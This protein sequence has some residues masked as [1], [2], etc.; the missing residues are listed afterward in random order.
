MCGQDHP[1]AE[2]NSRPHRQLFQKE[3]EPPDWR[4]IALP[5]PAVLKLLTDSHCHP[6][7]LPFSTAQVKNVGLGGLAAMATR[8]HDQQLVESFGETYG[9]GKDKVDDEDE[10]TQVVACFGYHP[11]FSHLLSLDT[12]KDP[13][14]KQ[15]HY[16]SIFIPS[17]LSP[18]KKDEYH[19]ILSRIIHLF[20]E[21]VRLGPLLVDMGQR[22]RR[23]LG[24]GQ[25]VMVGEIGLDRSFRIPY[26]PN[27]TDS[28]GTAHTTTTTVED[29][30]NAIAATAPEKELA[31]KQD[32][33][34]AAAKTKTKTKTLTPFTTSTAHQLRVL[35]LQFQVALDCGVNVSLHSVKAQGKLLVLPLF[36]H[37]THIPLICRLPMN[38]GVR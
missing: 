5:A 17:S 2:T 19:Q 13:L 35:E 25:K 1:T 28:E 37:R 9:S 14:D 20:P 7:D 10:N 21:P 30:E 36:L 6:T 24:R 3:D 26:P 12:S 15:Q 34:A 11:W 4:T 18:S 32:N 38:L 27:S 31:E 16:E 23:T 8:V 22:I 33:P 29:A